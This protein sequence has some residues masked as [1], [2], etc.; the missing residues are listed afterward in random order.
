MGRDPGQQLAGA[1]GF[2]DVV[3]GAD[4]QPDHNVNLF[5]LGAE[6]DDRHPQ[7]GFANVPADVETRNI[8]KHDV[9]Q[10]QVGLIELDAAEGLAAGLRLDH[11]VAF[12]L[13][14]EMDRLPD[15]RLIVDDQ[16]A[17]FGIFYGIVHQIHQDLVQLPRLTHD[18]GQALGDP[19]FQGAALEHRTDLVADVLHHRD[20]VDAR[21]VHRDPAGVDPAHRQ[22]IADQPLHPVGLA[23]QILQQLTPLGLAQ[24]KVEQELAEALERRE[25]RLQLVRRRQHQRIAG[26]DGLQLRRHVVDHDHRPVGG[27]A[28][29][30]QW[31]DRVGDSDRIVAGAQ[32]E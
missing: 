27:A 12:F 4:L 15:H 2:G 6:D 20:D 31:R 9:E 10:D 7:A 8:G 25:W 30:V 32:A 24:V 11:L 28:F 16:G 23:V 3:V 18:G 26:F 22:D 5:G 19:A 14:G 29:D 13:E 17:G 21:E 1:E